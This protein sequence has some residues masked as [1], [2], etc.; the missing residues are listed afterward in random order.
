MTLTGGTYLGGLGE[1]TALLFKI[2]GEE[3]NSN[4]KDFK[5]VIGVRG[6]GWTPLWETGAW[7]CE[8]IGRGNKNGITY[9]C[10]KTRFTGSKTT[11][12]FVQ[13]VGQEDFS[14]L[15]RNIEQ[16]TLTASPSWVLGTRYRGKTEFAEEAKCGKVERGETSS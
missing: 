13:V 2:G 4:F 5:G 16:S 11:L 12:V 10:T 15:T 9:P 6:K 8:K 7:K 3:K 14:N 1:S